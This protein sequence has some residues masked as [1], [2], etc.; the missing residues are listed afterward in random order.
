[1]KN[2]I[3]DFHAF[4]DSRLFKKIGKRS[5]GRNVFFKVRLFNNFNMLKITKNVKL[6]NKTNINYKFEGKIIFIA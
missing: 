3:L 6:N 4:G 1:M 5:T 2:L